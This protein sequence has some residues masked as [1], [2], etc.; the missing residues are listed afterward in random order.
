MCKQENLHCRPKCSYK[1]LEMA[2]VCLG[3][4]MVYQW[5]QRFWDGRTD[6]LNSCSTPLLSTHPYTAQILQ[7]WLCIYFLIYSDETA[8]TDIFRSKWNTIWYKR[9]TKT[10]QKMV[11]MCILWMGELKHKK[12]VELTGVYFEKENRIASQLFDINWCHR[13]MKW[14]SVN[15]IHA[16]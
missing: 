14:C 7:L 15:I 12:C 11:W 16:K 4:L 9:H 10:L 8:W 1:L 6:I 3:Q 5:N 2:H 13:N